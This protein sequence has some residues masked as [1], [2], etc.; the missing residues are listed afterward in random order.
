MDPLDIAECFIAL[1]PIAII[2]IA[3]IIAFTGR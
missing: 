2:T 1:G 3:I